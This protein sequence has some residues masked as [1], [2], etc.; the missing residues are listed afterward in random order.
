MEF[1]LVVSQIIINIKL[2]VLLFIFWRR[3]SCQCMISFTINALLNSAFFSFF[4]LNS[5]SYWQS[6]WCI[7]SKYK[8]IHNKKKNNFF[9]FLIHRF[10][11]GGRKWKKEKENLH[12]EYTKILLWCH[13]DMNMSVMEVE[14]ANPANQQHTFGS[15]AVAR[16]V[17]QHIYRET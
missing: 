4:W 16:A 10:F 6:Y 2:F 7:S 3:N 15:T 1:S 11:G 8:H 14:K 17:Y 5:H 13:I 12:F 9:L